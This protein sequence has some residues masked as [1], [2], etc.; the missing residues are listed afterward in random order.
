MFLS[1]QFERCKNVF[2]Q[3]RVGVS[4]M[5]YSERTRRVRELS[6]EVFSKMSN[7]LRSFYYQP[8]EMNIKPI[9]MVCCVS[10]ITLLAI[11]LFRRRNATSK[12]R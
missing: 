3:V 8:K 4:E 12:I 10:L 11:S 1:V 2:S 7:F 5:V 9:A 6:K